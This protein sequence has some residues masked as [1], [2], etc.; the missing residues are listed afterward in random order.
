MNDPYVSLEH[1]SEEEMNPETEYT[2]VFP[3]G[4]TC[5]LFAAPTKRVKTE[6]YEKCFEPDKPSFWNRICNFIPHT[7]SKPVIRL[8]KEQI[9]YFYEESII[10]F[11]SD[12]KA[13][14]VCGACKYSWKGEKNLP[15]ST[16]P[17][18][19]LTVIV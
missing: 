2:Q 6:D 11:F 16:C 17:N 14:F 18:C 7:E 10:P 8:G 4:E 13:T 12:G 9:A 19:K 1:I 5:G 15:T 3:M